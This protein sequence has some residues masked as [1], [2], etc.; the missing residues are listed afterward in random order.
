MSRERRKTFLELYMNGE[1]LAEEIDD[2]VDKWHDDSG[3]QPIYEFLGMSKQ[4]YSLW[5]RDPDVLPHIVRARREKKPLYKIISAA[6]EDMPIAARSDN[7]MKIQRLKQWLA[8]EG[9]TD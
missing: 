7:A 1:V 5:L 6:T 2:Y 9:K 8:R 4:E 3:D